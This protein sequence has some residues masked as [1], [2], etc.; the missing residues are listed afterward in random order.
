HPN[1][2]EEAEKLRTNIKQEETKNT[3]KIAKIIAGYYMNSFIEEYSFLSA[4]NDFS[5]KNTTNIIP[6]SKFLEREKQRL[7]YTKFNAF[8]D[9]YAKKHN[10]RVAK[11]L[12]QTTKDNSTK[13]PKVIVVQPYMNAGLGN[14][15]PVLACGFLYSMITDRLFFVEGFYNFTE[16]FEKDFD[17]DWKSVA[18]LYKNS[19]FR[20]LHD[21][22]EKN[23]FQ[24]ITRGNLSN[25]EINSY[26]I[27]YVHTWDYVKTQYYQ[28]VAN[29]VDNNFGEYNIGIHLRMRKNIRISAITPT[30]HFCHAAKMLMI[31][32]V[33]KNV[34]IF[35][36]AD[37][38]EN[39]NILINCLHSSL[40]SKNDSVNII[41]AGND[42]DVF[43]GDDPGTEI[44]AIIDL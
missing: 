14:R 23:D 4:N 36:A 10:R 41:H 2:K 34:T 7:T 43:V 9:D 40:G 44:G 16:Y 5:D 15:L 29:F 17:H 19:R 42:M 3:K 18:N 8:Y 38:N 26:D 12:N 39:R 6:S 24:L 11:L 25:E 37:D 28:K 33:K 27:L 1:M 31:G 20:Y 13:L 21:D 22:F 30:E 35:V 32:A